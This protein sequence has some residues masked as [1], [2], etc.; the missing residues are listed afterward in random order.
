LN[1]SGA[2]ENCA[3]ADTSNKLPGG[4]LISTSA[5]LV[6]FAVALNHGLL[7]KREALARMYECQRTRDGRPTNYGL[8]WRIFE[9]GGRKWVGHGGAQQG[10][11]STLLAS[12]ADGVAVS[13]MAN[14]EGAD[15]A[16]LCAEIAAV[17][18]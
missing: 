7:L 13:V 9:R 6:R 2:L 1:R 4:G 18:E 14:L 8:G 17:V 11:S 3:T 15:L 16:P 12:P 10:V 5:D